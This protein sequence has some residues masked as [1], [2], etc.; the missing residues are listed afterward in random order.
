MIENG[1]ELE[2]DVVVSNH[3]YLIIEIIVHEKE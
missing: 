2:K 1:L 3:Y